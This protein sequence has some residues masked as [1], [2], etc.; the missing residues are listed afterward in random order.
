MRTQE[1][2]FGNPHSCAP[3]LR[4]TLDG[5]SA[6]DGATLC[7]ITPIIASDYPKIVSELLRTAMRSIDICA[8]VWKWYACEGQGTMQQFN[9]LII[10]RARQG[11]PVRVRLNQEAKDHYL[12]K[13]NTL[14]A[15]EL[16]R[17]NVQTKFDHSGTVSHLKMIII[18]QEIVIIGS[19]NLS[20]RSVSQNNEASVAIFGREAAQK[21]CQYFEM[22]W[23]NQI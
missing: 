6:E 12:T 11:V 2:P 19:H 17:Y 9:R 7:K 22:L 21:F 15:S 14:T 3:G 20:K 4:A 16:R 18:D 10:D 13:Q 5:V 23:T 1:T 8:Y